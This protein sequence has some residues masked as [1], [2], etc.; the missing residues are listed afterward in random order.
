MY[1]RLDR[2]LVTFYV[3]HIMAHG[4]RIW[5]KPEALTR[6]AAFAYAESFNR[7]PRAR[8]CQQSAVI[9]RQ[10]APADLPQE[11]PTWNRSQNSFPTNDAC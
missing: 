3:I 11:L 10:Q 6:D 8:A 2:P 5:T 1:N 7:S 9:V 4:T